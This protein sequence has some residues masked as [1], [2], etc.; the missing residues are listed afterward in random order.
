MTPAYTR[1]GAVLRPSAVTHLFADAIDAELEGL[2]VQAA[3]L[4]AVMGLVAGVAVAAPAARFSGRVWARGRNRSGLEPN[5]RYRARIRCLGSQ[6]RAAA[7]ALLWARAQCRACCIGSGQTSGSRS[8]SAP[9]LINAGLVMC[10]GDALASCFRPRELRDF[11]RLATRRTHSNFG[12]A[13]VDP[14]AG[15]RSYHI[16]RLVAATL[17]GSL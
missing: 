8:G 14:R 15:G 13:A 11:D 2:H 16:P 5:H 7:L 1:G 12:G 4:A 10:L 17:R 9:A 6:R 3:R